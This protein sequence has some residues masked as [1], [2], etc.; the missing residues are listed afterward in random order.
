MQFFLNPFSSSYLSYTTIY[1]GAPLPPL[2]WGV[3]RSKFYYILA[4]LLGENIYANLW[5]LIYIHS[6]CILL[7]LRES[8]WI[9]TKSSWGDSPREWIRMDSRIVAEFLS[10][11]WFCRVGVIWTRVW[12]IWFEI[13]AFNGW[14]I[15]NIRQKSQ[16]LV[17]YS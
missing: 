16:S 14:T 8:I 4:N 7:T 17:L 2:F 15:C 13:H 10:L 11:V 12:V 1:P 3:C 9:L 5:I 6:Q